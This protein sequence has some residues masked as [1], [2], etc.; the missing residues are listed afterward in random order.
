MAETQEVWFKQFVFPDGRIR[1]IVIDSATETAILAQ[2]LKQAGYSF[3][4]EIKDSL[5]WATII[6]HTTE[7][8]RDGFIKNGP[9]VPEMIDNLIK[10]AHHM[11][12][13]LPTKIKEVPND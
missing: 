8:F 12:I 11:L 10:D 4:I 1:D 13:K 7:K 6:N 5:V 3:E 2:E 9:G